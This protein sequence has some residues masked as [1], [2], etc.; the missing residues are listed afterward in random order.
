MFPKVWTSFGSAR[1]SAVLLPDSRHDLIVVLL[2]TTT[3]KG[4]ERATMVTPLFVRTQLL[5][6]TVKA[7]MT[8]MTLNTGHLA[9]RWCVFTRAARTV[10]RLGLTVV[11]TWVFALGRIWT[12]TLVVKLGG[13]AVSI[14]V[15]LV[16]PTVLQIVTSCLTFRLIFVC[17]SVA[18]LV[19]V[20]PV[21]C[22]RISWIPS[23]RLVVVTLL[24]WWLRLVSVWLTVTFCSC[25]ALVRVIV[26]GM[27]LYLLSSV[28]GVVMVATLVL[29]LSVWVVRMF[30]V[31]VRVRLAMTRTGS[32]TGGSGRSG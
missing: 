26:L 25:R 17:W 10:V 29:R 6:I 11:T 5:K 14:V 2:T 24:P 19:V 4:S 30:M 3:L 16:G 28:V 9:R 22:S 21:L 20:V 27:L 15:V 12:R 31:V 23:C 32:D 1:P 8:F 13:K 18:L 7:S